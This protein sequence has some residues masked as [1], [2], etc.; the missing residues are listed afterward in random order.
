MLSASVA[1]GVVITLLTG[2]YNSTP[3]GLVGAAWY[4]FP[5]TWIRRLVV[6]PQYYPWVVDYPG[7]VT[8]IVFWAV[9]IGITL[10]IA[11]RLTYHKTEAPL[12]KR[13]E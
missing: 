7:L 6:A 12:A 10:S 4:G 2:L 13:V 1:F 8:D 11:V 9:L 3:G 5:L